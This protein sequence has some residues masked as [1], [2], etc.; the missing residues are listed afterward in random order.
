MVT[1]DLL[2]YMGP[3][4]W[5]S[6]VLV[7]DYASLQVSKKLKLEKWDFYQNLGKLTQN[8]ILTVPLVLERL[9]CA[10]RVVGSRMEGFGVI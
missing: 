6:V 9:I 7:E 10:R 2:W 1:L 8:G 5:L 4:E 3:L